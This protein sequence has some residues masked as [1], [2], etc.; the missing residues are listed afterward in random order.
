MGAPAAQPWHL[1]LLIW[2]GL[3]QVPALDEISVARAKATR[4]AQRRLMVEQ[5]LR[6]GGSP[7]RKNEAVR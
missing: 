7:A 2:L 3:D 5:G 4:A 6:D 1:G